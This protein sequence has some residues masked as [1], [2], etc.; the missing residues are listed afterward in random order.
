M[1]DSLLVWVLVSLLLMDR[2]IVKA[3][4]RETRIGETHRELGMD[5]GGIYMSQWRKISQGHRLL[6]YRWK[7]TVFKKRRKA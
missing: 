6:P 2:N 4:L 5:F 1:R 7:I 3:T